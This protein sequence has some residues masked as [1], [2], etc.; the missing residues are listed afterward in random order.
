MEEER[1][2]EK[3][4]SQ[5]VLRRG[6]QRAIDRQREE[7]SRQRA[8]GGGQPDELGILQG[9]SGEAGPTVAKPNKVR[10]QSRPAH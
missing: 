10:Q 3:T 5:R 7:Q 4:K 1:G 9:Q 2:V 6:R 8:L